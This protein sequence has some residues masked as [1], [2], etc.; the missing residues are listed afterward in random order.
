MIIIIFSCILVSGTYNY[1]L[2]KY[3]NELEV[4]ILYHKTN[5]LIESL[6]NVSYR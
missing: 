5:I 3:Y 1:N 2:Y 4:I 6:S